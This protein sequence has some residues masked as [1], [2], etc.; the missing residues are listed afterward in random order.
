M[1]VEG[2][3][4][5]GSR[6]GAPARDKARKPSYP[7][8]P[9]DTPVS[10]RKAERLEGEGAE[11]DCEHSLPSTLFMGAC[12]WSQREIAWRCWTLGIWATWC[13]FVGSGIINDLWGEMASRGFPH[14]PHKARF[15]FRYGRLGEVRHAVGILSGVAGNKGRFT[16]FAL[17]EG[18]HGGTGWP[19]G[20]FP[21]FVGFA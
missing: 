12:L 20:F 9:L 7:A 8:L 18:C 19:V 2:H 10:A 11:S 1:P 17:R 4:E 15:R 3:P 16:A 5:R 13:V 21:P 6:P 14:T